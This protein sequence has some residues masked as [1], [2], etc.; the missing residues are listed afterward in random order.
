MN[1]INKVIEYLKQVYIEMRKVT[2]P[3]RN[4]LVGST[5]VVVVISVIVA[6]IIF[7]LDK[8]FTTVLTLII[9]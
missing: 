4:E 6:L 5:I 9:R 8:I 3:G 1:I 7:A 2:W